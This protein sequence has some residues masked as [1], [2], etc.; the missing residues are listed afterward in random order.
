MAKVNG[1]TAERMLAIEAASIVD[2]TIDSNGH[3]ILSKFDGQ[4][5]DAGSAIV[6]FPDDAI[7]HKLDSTYDS[8]TPPT[9]YPDGISY[10][11]ID[12]S[13]NTTTWPQFSGKWGSLVTTKHPEGDAT[14]TWSRLTGGA[15][16]PERWMRTG[17][18]SQSWT[19]WKRLTTSDDI[20]TTFVPL[21]T[22]SETTPVTSYPLGVSIMVIGSGSGWTPTE[23][24]TV[25]TYNQSDTRSY[26]ELHRNDRNDAWKRTYYSTSGWTAWQ[27]Y[28]FTNELYVS[29]AIGSGANLDTYT[30]PGIYSQNT[31]SGASGGTNYPVARAGIL[32]VRTSSTGSLIWQTYTSYGDTYGKSFYKRSRTSSGSWLAWQE[33]QPVDDTGWQTLTLNAGFTASGGYTPRVR[34]RNGVVYMDGYVTGNYGTYT[35]YVTCLTLP[36]GFRPSRP[37]GF[38]STANSPTNLAINVGTD[39]AVGVY[40]AASTTAWIS[41]SNVVFPIG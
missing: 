20:L 4:T 19:V 16:T 30:T 12:G 29:T 31:D 1:L 8:L 13:T 6:A 38:A 14:Q 41:F 28:V 17:S 9:S 11:W 2:G 27:R 15:G 21:N 18:P 25:V 22:H 26:Q 33:Y 24:G 34:K 35:G 32:E 7:I 39:G 40:A 5:V 10:L 3:L 36:S 37:L 23:F